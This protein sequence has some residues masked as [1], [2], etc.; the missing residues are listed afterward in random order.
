MPV[1]SSLNLGSVAVCALLASE[2]RYSVGKRIPSAY[3][4]HRVSNY[5]LV[6]L[7]QCIICFTCLIIISVICSRGSKTALRLIADTDICERNTTL[8][9]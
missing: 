6:L 4:A 3:H 9:L 2:W 5:Y 7:H 8:T 1:A